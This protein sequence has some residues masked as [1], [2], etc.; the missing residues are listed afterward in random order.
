M[1]MREFDRWLQTFLPPGRLMQFALVMF[2][3][4]LSGMVA[5]L[6]LMAWS[7]R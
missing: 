3:L 2:I 5:V 7:A 6:L 1:S 4:N